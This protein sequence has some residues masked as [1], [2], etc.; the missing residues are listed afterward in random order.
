MKKLF[1]I[2]L[3]M[4][5]F[6]V[7]VETAFTDSDADRS[8]YTAE[9]QAPADRF[10]IASFNLQSF[11]LS[12]TVD[13][14]L[15][16]DFISRFEIAAVQNIDG[17][18][19]ATA[20]LDDILSAVNAFGNDYDYLIGPSVGDTN[21]H[22]AFIYRSDMAVPVQWS[23]FTGSGTSDF[24]W[25]PF[26]TRFQLGGDGFDITLANI[27]VE[28]DSRTLGI[29][30]LPV[31]VDSIK[32]AFPDETDIILLGDMDT[33]CQ[34]PETEGSFDSLEQENY[35]DLIPADTA[36]NTDPVNCSRARIIVASYS[37]ELFWEK[38]GIL[39]I[40]GEADSA[41]QRSA[42]ESNSAPGYTALAVVGDDDDPETEGS[43]T[44]GFCFFKASS[45]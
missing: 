10:S 5:S 9:S 41:L 18:G 13:I 7:A 42:G 3:V 2:L 19:S 16:A 24:R 33:G 25:P 36:A 26:I 31:L 30:L 29:E 40:D 34:D 27:L 21:T 15:L 32:K 23:T 37:D 14:E 28:S 6:F 38:S 22:Y 17:A 1:R 12:D 20:L 35:I 43:Q 39:R 45:N 4:V 11:R 44:G 8:E